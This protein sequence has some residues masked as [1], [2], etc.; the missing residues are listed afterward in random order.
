MA[1]DNL[2]QLGK[3]FRGNREDTDSS[4]R[5]FA[6][7]YPMI[8][9][10]REELD[11]NFP[12]T[13]E[14]FTYK[15]TPNQVF[16]DF[17]VFEEFNKD[18]KFDFSYIPVVISQTGLAI[19]F[20][21]PEAQVGVEGVWYP[22]VQLRDINFLV[23]NPLSVVFDIQKSGTMT[24]EHKIVFDGGG[25][26]LTGVTTIGA[27]TI[28]VPISQTQV[29][30]GTEVRDAYIYGRITG[31]SVAGY[32]YYAAANIFDQWGRIYTPRGLP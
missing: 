5:R 21:F 9:C 1:S 31:V 2:K 27:S 6:E 30:G 8:E 25:V 18:A 24:I 23:T 3:T 29:T 13:M 26:D 22:L 11:P 15:D 7:N 12:F 16:L 28:T 10:I 19:G 4:T 14:F 17:K 32:L 20:D